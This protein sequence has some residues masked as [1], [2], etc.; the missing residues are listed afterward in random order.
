ML[1]HAMYAGDLAIFAE[2]MTA[3]QAMLNHVQ[4]TFATAGLGLSLRARDP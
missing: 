1:S 2:I 4:T 3:D